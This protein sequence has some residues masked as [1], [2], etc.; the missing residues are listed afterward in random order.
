MIITNNGR[1]I[2]L[3]EPGD[4]FK[5]VVGKPPEARLIKVKAE[6]VEDEDDCTGCRFEKMCEK[7]NVTDFVCYGPDR[8]DNTSIKIVPFT[9]EP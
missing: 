8:Y 5:I 1:P 6:K 7:F 2:I 3:P 9:P 4:V